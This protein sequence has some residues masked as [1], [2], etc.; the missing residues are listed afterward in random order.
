M[1]EIQLTQGKVA[2][3]DDWNYD[4]LNM[5]NWCAQKTPENWYAVRHIRLQNPD[6]PID[7]QPENLLISMHRQIL[8]P[9][10]GYISDHI[11]HNGLN[12][13]ESNLRV[14]TFA[15]NQRNRQKTQKKTSSQYKGVW[16][17]K[18]HKRWVTNI[19]DEYVGCFEDEIEAAKAYDTK[20][21]ELFGEFACL[22]FPPVIIEK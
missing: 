19:K 3:V 21:L 15:Q 6:Y 22:N 5:D 2:I 12:N 20:A 8:N 1:K 11:D 13:L 17:D 16:R 7:K 9:P 14:C 4:W 18:K 10:A